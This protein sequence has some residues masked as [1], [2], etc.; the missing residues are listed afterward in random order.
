MLSMLCSATLSKACL[1][2]VAWSRILFDSIT[3][4]VSY[5]FI[6]CLIRRFY[7]IYNYCYNKFLVQFC[8]PHLIYVSFVL[9]FAV[10]IFFPL[11]GFLFFAFSFL[12]WLRGCIFCFKFYLWLSFTFQSD[13]LEFMNYQIKSEILTLSNL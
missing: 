7:F 11:L 13:F 8:H 5:L 3:I 9:S 12:Q 2:E 10:H 6:C 4:R 1:L